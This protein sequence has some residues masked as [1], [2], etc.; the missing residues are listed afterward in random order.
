MARELHDAISEQLA[1]RPLIH[2]LGPYG[3]ESHR[4]VHSAR[5]HFVS[6]LDRHIL[7]RS[8][9]VVFVIEITDDYCLLKLC[10]PLMLAEYDR[11][12][13]SGYVPPVRSKI[14]LAVG[15]GMNRDVYYAYS[16]VKLSP[17]GRANEFFDALALLGREL[18]EYI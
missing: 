18:E 1:S 2:S 5:R 7:E 13:G 14:Y 4:T 10:C 3:R 15:F 6:V 9:S 17:H 11:V 12:S 16:A 8:Q